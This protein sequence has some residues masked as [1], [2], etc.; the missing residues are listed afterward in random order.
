MYE[1]REMFTLI[2]KL[3]ANYSQV[4]NTVTPWPGKLADPKLGWAW[5]IL[6]H[7]SAVGTY[8]KQYE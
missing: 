6:G 4:Y 5:I 3:F 7:C 8:V 2:K 1:N